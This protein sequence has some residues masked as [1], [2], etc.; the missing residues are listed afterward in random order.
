[1]NTCDFCGKLEAKKRFCNKKCKDS[2]YYKQSLKTLICFKC[3]VHFEATVNRELCR[4]CSQS[5]E[6]S[7]TWKGGHKLWQPGK[8]GRDKDGLSWKVQRRLCRERDNYTCQDCGK[9]REELGYIPH[10]DHEIPYRISFSHALDNLKLR[11]RSCHKKAEARRPELWGGKTFGGHVGREPTPLCNI[12]KKRR[13]LIEGLCRPCRKIEIL[14]PKALRL[15]DKGFS[16]ESIGKELGVTHASISM[17]LRGSN[18]T[19]VDL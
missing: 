9:T 15:R 3:K 14:I 1:M 10:C 13:R 11:C 12:C 16:M 7:P 2:F 19:A 18:G 17:W 8:L 4:S 5:G 6:K